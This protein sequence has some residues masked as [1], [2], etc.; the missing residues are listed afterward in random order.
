MSDS[1]VPDFD[2][3]DG[4]DVCDV[5]LTPSLFLFLAKVCRMFFGFLLTLFLCHQRL[6][7]NLLLF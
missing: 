1:D 7:Y 6:L 5:L 2:C 3:V 4:L